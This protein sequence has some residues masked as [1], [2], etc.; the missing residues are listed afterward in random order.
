MTL[1]SS[2]RVHGPDVF[3][4]EDKSARKGKMEY[5]T[6]GF[7]KQSSANRISGDVAHCGIPTLPGFDAKNRYNP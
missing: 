1:I 5:E 2:S 7:Q 6:R 3:S 4:S